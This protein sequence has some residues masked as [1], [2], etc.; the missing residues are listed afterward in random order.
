MAASRSEVV[1]CFLIPPLSR[2]VQSYITPLPIVA[3]STKPEGGFR[4]EQ[5]ETGTKLGFK[6]MYPKGF[7]LMAN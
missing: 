5:D 2:Y 4:M 7:L 1:P 3:K 6:P